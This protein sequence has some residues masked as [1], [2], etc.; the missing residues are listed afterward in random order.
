MTVYRTATRYYYATVAGWRL[1]DCAYCENYYSRIRSAY[2]EVA[3]YLASLG[4]DIEKPLEIAPP[5]E[6]NCYLFCQYV[7]F[8]SCPD[9]YR[10]RVGGLTFSVTHSFP[11]PGIRSEAPFFVLEAFNVPLECP[12]P[13]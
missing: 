5:V 7:V 1:C 6:A 10:H 12:Y 13:L 8:G 4:A 2:P 3:A 9:T 11:D